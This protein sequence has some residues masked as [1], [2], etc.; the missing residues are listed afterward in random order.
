MITSRRELIHK[1]GFTIR[2]RS[3]DDP[4]D[5]NN[6][7]IR[8]DLAIQPDDALGTPDEAVGFAQRAAEISKFQDPGIL[9]S[10]AAA[11]A[12]AGQ[13]DQ[14]VAVARQALGLASAV[15]ER[16][17]AKAIQEH[18]DCYRDGRPYRER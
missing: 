12:A 18:L 13:F 1:P 6:P 14:A 5:P 3:G 15:Q 8:D 4:N 10:L 17:V 9:D 2:R 16:K 11:L 7:M